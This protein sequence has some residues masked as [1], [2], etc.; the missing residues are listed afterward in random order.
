M[1]DETPPKPD[2]TDKSAAPGGPK[3]KPVRRGKGEP[4]G[5]KPPS[6]LWVVLALAALVAGLFLVEQFSGPTGVDVPYARFL[7]EAKAGNVAAATQKGEVLTGKWNRP[8][9]VRERPAKPSPPRSAPS[10]RP[11]RRSGAS[12]PR[13]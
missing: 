2:R 7:E 11:G 13:R 10:S 8:P 9:D 3:D 5:K 12:R 4:Q 6:A 1:P